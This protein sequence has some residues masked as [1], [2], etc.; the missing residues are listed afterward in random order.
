MQNW[1][2]RIFKYLVLQLT[3]LT[4]DGIFKVLEMKINLN[5]IEIF[6][7]YKAVNILRLAYKIL[8]VHFFTEISAL[9]SETRKNALCGLKVEFCMLNV[10]AYEL[11]TGLYIHVTVHHNRFI[12]K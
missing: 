7:S 1:F 9:F 5:Y 4:G 6:I 2:S 8:S 3:I 10:V 11:T 12:F